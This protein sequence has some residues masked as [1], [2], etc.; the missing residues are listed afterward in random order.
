M[1]SII[2]IMYKICPLNLRQGRPH[3]LPS[4][5]NPPHVRICTILADPSPFLVP[6][7]QTFFMDGPDEMYNIR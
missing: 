1:L 5:P 7:V 6:S 3:I 2:N 4:D